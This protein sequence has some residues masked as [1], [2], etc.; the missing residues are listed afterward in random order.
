M[1]ERTADDPGA[2]ATA[3]VGVAG[4]LCVV[5]AVLGLEL[6]YHHTAER[7]RRERD[8]APP[9]ELSA[10][11]RAEQELLESYRWID[12]QRGIVAIPVERAMELLLEERGAPEADR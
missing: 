1:A 3:L 8:S 7:A 10:V 11:R 9:A 5:L 12:R 2:G 4:A 6:L